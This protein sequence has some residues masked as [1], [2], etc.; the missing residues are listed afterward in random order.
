MGSICPVGTQERKNKSKSWGANGGVENADN[1]SGI[2]GYYLGSLAQTESS[3]CPAVEPK[4][5]SPPAERQRRRTERENTV[6]VLVC[7]CMS[8][9]VSPLPA[10]GSTLSFWFR[11]CWTGRDGER[12]GEKRWEE[13]QPYPT[14]SLSIQWTLQTMP[15]PHPHRLSL[16]FYF[17][18]RRLALSHRK[19]PALFFLL[20]HICEAWR[21]LKENKG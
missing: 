17:S 19:Q 1:I 3:C 14:L 21:P 20:S 11:S 5:R 4:H 7:M 2:V 9:K 8:V 13:I 6:C 15:P 18:L 10:F 12:G 16:T